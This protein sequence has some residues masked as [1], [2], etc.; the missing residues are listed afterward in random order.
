MTFRVKNPDVNLSE[1]P[2]WKKHMKWDSLRDVI[3]GMA[4]GKAVEFEPANQKELRVVRQI[5]SDYG[6]KTGKA[7]SV[8]KISETSYALTRTK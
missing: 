4:V 2:Q 8:I 1:I 6:L 7:F 3:E 5:V